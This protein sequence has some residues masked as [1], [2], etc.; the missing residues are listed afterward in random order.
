M[1]APRRGAEGR[2]LSEVERMQPRPRPHPALGY[3]GED[4]VGGVIQ[5][6]TAASLTCTF[7][8][9]EAQQ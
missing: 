3:G 4:G 5:V 8:T 1:V 7:V 6:C 2:V 9:N